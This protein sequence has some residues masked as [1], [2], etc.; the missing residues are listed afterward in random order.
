MT[1]TSFPMKRYTLLRR[2]DERE[3]GEPSPAADGPGVRRLTLIRR[4]QTWPALPS[5]G[6]RSGASR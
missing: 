5:G 6:A 3:R 4:A 2:A 1:G